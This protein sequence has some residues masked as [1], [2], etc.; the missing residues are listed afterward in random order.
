M[1]FELTQK[2]LNGEMPNDCYS[3]ANSKTKLVALIK[4]LGDARTIA[5]DLPYDEGFHFGKT[6]NGCFFFETDEFLDSEE[7]KE[8]PDYHFAKFD[9]AEEGVE[10]FKIS[11]KD[12]F[13]VVKGRRFFAND[14]PLIYD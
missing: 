12:L 3:I 14:C 10:K 1:T 5:K 11:G 9:T 7:E 13:S 2:Y 6:S 4:E 8:N